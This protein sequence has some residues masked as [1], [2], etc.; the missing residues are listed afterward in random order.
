MYFCDSAKHQRFADVAPE[1]MP[2]TREGRAGQ[3][4]GHRGLAL[5][6]LR[7]EPVRKLRTRPGRRPVFRD[8]APEDDGV[9]A[10]RMVLSGMY[11]V[12]L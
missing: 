6:H 2:A 10:N 7:E 9:T 12:D 1:P 11:T 5:R 3:Q 8:T 4:I